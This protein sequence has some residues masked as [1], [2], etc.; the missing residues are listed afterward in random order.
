MIDFLLYS[1][2]SRVTWIP[3]EYDL[4]EN[5]VIMLGLDIHVEPYSN[6]MEYSNMDEKLL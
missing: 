1:K 6:V 3:I 4:S 5:G 2:E